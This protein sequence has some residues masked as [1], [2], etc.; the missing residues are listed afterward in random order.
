MTLLNY[1]YS[2]TA[3]VL[4]LVV[5]IMACFKLYVLLVTT[6]EILFVITLV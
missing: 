3:L 2:P 6:M 5:T 4:F 1:V